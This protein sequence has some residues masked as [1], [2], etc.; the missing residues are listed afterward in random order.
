M[1]GMNQVEINRE[2]GHFTDEEVDG[3]STLEREKG[4]PEN[5]RGHREKQSHGVE[6]GLVHHGSRMRVLPSLRRLTQRLLPLRSPADFL[7]RK[8]CHVS[9]VFAA[10]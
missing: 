1:A 6:V 9:A 4:I 10:T 7:C 8:P 5:D 3:S 2:S